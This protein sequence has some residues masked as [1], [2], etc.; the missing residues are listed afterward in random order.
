MVEGVPSGF[1][2]ASGSAK[3]VQTGL[4]SQSRLGHD[5]PARDILKEDSGKVNRSAVAREF[6]TGDRGK[7]VVV[8]EDT[9]RMHRTVGIALRKFKKKGGSPNLRD[10]ESVEKKLKGVDP[11]LAHPLDD[12][13]IEF[14]VC[15]DFIPG[16]NGMEVDLRAGLKRGLDV[17]EG[18]NK[19]IKISAR[20][21][22]QPRQSQ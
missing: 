2:N 15:S 17:D 4:G 19:R 5:V 21:V 12:S 3:G 13:L 8:Q 14:E 20:A 9:S 18:Q 1:S 16:V 7:R 6:G 11:R 10:G 22:G